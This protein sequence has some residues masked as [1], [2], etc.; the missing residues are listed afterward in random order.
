[1]CSIYIYFDAESRTICMPR[2]AFQFTFKL[3]AYGARCSEGPEKD[4]EI[5]RE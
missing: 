5:A 1:M 2:D 3:V 4:A